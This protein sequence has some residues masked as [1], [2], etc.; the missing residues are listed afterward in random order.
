MTTSP[1]IGHSDLSMTDRYS[2]IT[3][4]QKQLWQDKLF[5]QYANGRAGNE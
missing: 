5:E 4:N 2:H 1:A 3:I